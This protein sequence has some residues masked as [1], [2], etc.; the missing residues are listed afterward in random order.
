MNELVFFS[1]IGA[2]LFSIY[3]F[4]K[5]GKSGLNVLFVLQIIFANLFILKQT[6]LF[7]LAVTTTD[8]YTIG[9]FL[10]L[11]IIRECFGKK[12]AHKTITLGLISVL[13]LPFMS[14]FLLSYSSIEDGAEFSNLYQSL[15]TPSLRIFITSIFCMVTFQKLDT[16]IFSKLRKSYSLE[17]SMLT[18]LLCTQFL[19]TFFFTYGALSGILSN[20]P[21]IVFFSYLIKVITI[22]VMT[23]ATKTLTKR[24]V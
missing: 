12:E 2:I 21:S 13:F 3:T 1:H 7:G 10:T 16:Y 8:C 20:L 5:L 19:D 11:N 22:L 4:S 24:I 23:P 9:S 18:S 15:L 6:S 17:I 14:M